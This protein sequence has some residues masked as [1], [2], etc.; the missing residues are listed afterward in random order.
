MSLREKV[1]SLFRKHPIGLIDF[2]VDDLWVSPTNMKK[3]A[4]AIKKGT[5]GVEVGDT[6]PLLAAAYSRKRLILRKET[7]ADY[8][9]G[10]AAIVHEG[11]HAWADMASFKSGLLDECAAYLTEVIYLKHVNRRISGHP[12]YDAAGALADT[13]K[14]YEK[15]RAH[16]TRSDCRTLSDAILSGSQVVVDLLRN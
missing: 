1:E 13:H 10:R 6:G 8:P 15:R 9:E 2:Y 11:V 12:I 3:V 4:N 16:L 7:E 14:L 5:I